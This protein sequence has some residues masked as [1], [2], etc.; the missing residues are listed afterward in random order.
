[1]VDK[2]ILSLP[3][4]SRGNPEAKNKEPDFGCFFFFFRICFCYRYYYYD[5]IHSLFSKLILLQIFQLTSG[6]A[7]G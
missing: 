6:N 7:S 2:A 1:M 4:A 3:K 5:V